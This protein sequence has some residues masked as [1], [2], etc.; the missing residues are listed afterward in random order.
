MPTVV[1]R[2]WEYWRLR[3]A[4]AGATP[5]RRGVKRSRGLA[6]KPNRG[7]ESPRR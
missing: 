7:V 2:T 6:V 5:P 1:S 4:A 3:L